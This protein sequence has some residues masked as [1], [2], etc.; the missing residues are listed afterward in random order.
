[1]RRPGD[2]KRE[3]TGTMQARGLSHRS[4]NFRNLIRA[5][6]SPKPQEGESRGFFSKPENQ[7]SEIREA[8]LSQA[9]QKTRKT[10]LQ[11]GRRLLR[12]AKEAEAEGDPE[13]AQI[14]RRTLGD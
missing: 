14:Y 7:Y 2:A 8:N 11:D 5:G 6:H 3:A 13:K 1:M 10:M 12:M 4:R 9:D